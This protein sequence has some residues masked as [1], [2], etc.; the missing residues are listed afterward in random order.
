MP[1]VGGGQTILVLGGGI[2]GVVA[3][4]RLHRRLGHRHRIILVNRDPDFAFAAS[5]L[6]VMAGWRSPAQVTKPLRRLSRKGIDVVIGE[7]EAIDAAG[8][9]VVVSGRPITA[10]HLVVTLGA[11]YATD[12]IPGLGEHGQTFA[13]LAGARTLG[14]ALD[15]IR[16]GRILVVTGAPVYRCPAAPYEAAFLIDSQLRRRGIRD[17]VDVAIHSAEAMP[18]GVAGVNVADAVKGMLG[19]RGIGYVSSHQVTEVEARQAIFADADRQP[20]D[21]LVHM[22]PIAPPRVVAE[23]DLAG[24]G[25][26]IHGERT[27]LTTGFENVYALGDNFQTPLGIGKPLPRAGVF[28]HAQARVVADN[29]AARIKGREP[30]ARFDGHGGCFIETGDGLAGYG[31]GNFFADPSPSVEVRSPNRLQHLGKV[32]FEKRAMWRWLA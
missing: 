23:S 32:A 26:W 6:W 13:T 16:E 30:V 22:P 8:R 4:N 28:A 25:G 20:F 14:V 27:T 5:Y 1:A 9:S 15:E 21:L 17:R 2:G 10:D 31:S 19:E 3:A 7:V 18:M 24:E 29:I 12:R 11:D